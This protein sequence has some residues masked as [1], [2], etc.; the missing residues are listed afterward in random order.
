MIAT[1]FFLSGYGLLCSLFISQVA[2]PEKL[3]SEK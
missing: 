3:A 1:V 2:Q